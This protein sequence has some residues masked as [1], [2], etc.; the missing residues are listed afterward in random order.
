MNGELHHI[1]ALQRTADHQRAAECARLARQLDI[2][3][4]DSRRSHSITRLSAQLA[5]L[6]SRR[7]SIGLRNATDSARTPRAQDPVVD[8]STPTE[9]SHAVVP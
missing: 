2:G 1:L 5:R 3:L 8:M 7:T 4:R 9:T 6:T